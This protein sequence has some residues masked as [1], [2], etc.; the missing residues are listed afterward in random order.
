VNPTVVYAERGTGDRGPRADL[1]GICRIIVGTI[2]MG[3]RSVALLLIG[4]TS[5][6]RSVGVNSVSNLPTY[7]QFCAVSLVLALGLFCAHSGLAHIQIGW[8]RLLGHRLPERYV[9]PFMATSPADFWNRWNTWIGRWAYRYIYIPLGRRMM[10][11]LRGSLAVTW[12]LLLSF[13]GV[14]FLHDFGVFAVR[15]GQSQGSV[16]LRFTF[17]FGIFGLVLVA[18]REGARFV[19]RFVDR[20]ARWVR[21]VGIVLARLL[22]VQIAILLLWLAIPV[23]RSNVLP[24]TLER[25]WRWSL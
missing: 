7:V 10:R 22:L 21:C 13:L 14:G 15:M 23:L 2:T 12:A 9:Y 16:S 6:L 8:M 1:Q 5:W 4:R 20:Q 18:W 25:I 11:A 3:G 24:P 17:I 19:R